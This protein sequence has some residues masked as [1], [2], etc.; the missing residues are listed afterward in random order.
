M[1]RD[2][3]VA[4]RAELESTRSSTELLD[5]LLSP[6]DA[7]ARIRTLPG[8]ALYRLVRRIGLEDCTEI[9]ALSSGQQVQ[10]FIDFDAWQGDRLD[11]ERLDP[12][13]RALMVSGREVLVERLLDLDDQLL[14]WIVL[15]SAQIYVIDD[16]E[17]FEAPDEEHVLTQ[18]RRLCIVFPESAERDLPV[19]VFLDAFM[20]EHPD[21][22]Y[23][24]LVFTG[25]ALNSEL[26]E[27]ALR[28][29]QGRLADLGFVE[30]IEALGL[31]TAPRPDQIRDARRAVPRGVEAPVLAQ[32]LRSDERLNAGIA[33]LDAQTRA[34]V[35]QELAYV[36]NTALSADRVPLWDEAA[37]EHVLRRVRAG[38]SLGLDALSE[39]A[40]PRSDADVLAD[41]PLALVFRAGYGRMLEAAEPARRARRRG[42]LSGPGGP[43]D[44]VDQPLLRSW[45]EALTDR[46][47]H[48]PD[49]RIPRTT[50]D[51][52]RMRAF[53]EVVADLVDFPAGGRS[54]DAGLCA[55]VLTQVVR[56][57]LGLSDFGRVPAPRLAE[58][59]ALLF[60]QGGLSPAGR[61]AARAQWLEQGGRRPQTIDF[62]LTWAAEELA[63][64]DPTA[65][66][67]RFCTALLLGP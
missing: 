64:V 60:A 50:A 48:L 25:A 19:K 29:R 8:E 7:P 6:A 4:W 42:L 36:C 56:G 13:L 45:V 18:D 44:A 33:T 11:I 39:G 63:A 15:S 37:Q 40:T 54:D 22:C 38:L 47:P 27:N 26:E 20:R 31:Y 9:V 59:H 52:A 10:A 53:A 57:L 51:L 35:L 17:S 41:V 65:L 30:P 62:L 67:G 5:H 16:P 3:L 61:E 12:W 23:N 14:S 28:W 43:V 55:W 49:D 46:H 66:E 24:F 21:H 58:A 1:T 34:V 2:E 32:S